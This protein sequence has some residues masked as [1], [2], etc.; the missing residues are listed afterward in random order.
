MRWNIYRKMFLFATMMIVLPVALLGFL[1]YREA[2]AMLISR[3]KQSSLLT[4]ENAANHFIKA[5]I[6]DIETTMNILSNDPMLA[7]LPA[8]QARSQL[9]E[10]WEQH[11]RYS[12][13]IWSI[14]YTSNQ[15]ERFMIPQR[16]MEAGYISPSRNAVP[17]GIIWSK[18]QRDETTNTTVVTA[19]KAIYQDGQLI[20]VFAIDT[21]LYKLSD[22]IHNIHIGAGGY[23]ILLDGSG[24]VIAH[25]ELAMLGTNVRDTDWFKQLTQSELNFIHIADSQL[26]VSS[27]NIPETGW[28]LVGFLPESL[29]VSEAEPIKTTTLEVALLGII[30]ASLVSAVVSRSFVGRIKKLVASVVKIEQGDYQIR[31]LDQSTD[32]I[33]ELSRKF[34]ATADRLS[35]FMEQRDLNEAE[36]QRQKIYFAQLFE[37]SPESIVILDPAGRIVTVNK[38][39]T[40]LFHYTEAEAAGGWIDDLVVPDHLKAEGIDVGE[41]IA[42]HEFVQQETVRKRRD[43]SL[44]EVQ[45][46]AYPIIVDTQI[47]GVYAIYRD[48]SVRKAAEHQLEYLTYHD[49]LT[50]VYNRGYFDRRIQT[51]LAHEAGGYGIVVFDVD[52]LKLVNDSFGHAKGDEL[53]KT[54]VSL[55]QSAAPPEAIIARMG[56]DEF[57][58]LWPQA[59]EEQL[60]NMMKQLLQ[61]ISDFNAAHP[62]F[63]V[64]LSIGFALA[65][66]SAHII[67]ALQEADSRMYK[68]K[69]HRSQSTR[70]AI[71]KTLMRALHARDYITE[72]HGDRIQTMIEQLAERMGISGYKIQDLRLFAQFH[73]LG[74]VGIP[75]SI[76]F[77]SGPLTAKELE[78]MRRH[79]E[80]G[81]RIAISSPELNHIADWILKHHEWWNG[82]G[83]P[84]G[85]SGLEIPLECRILAICD[86]Y[87]AMTSERPYRKAMPAETALV[88]IEKCR[89]SMFDPEIAGIFVA[90]IRG[91]THERL[92]GDWQI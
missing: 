29:F 12:E 56:G 6:H 54:A 55:I 75:D 89:G 46:I 58:L 80:I 69:L 62:E 19:S 73:D 51:L 15:G 1:S 64:S 59:T 65:E 23:L 10:K 14:A 48:I 78:V 79:S 38:Q 52:G 77:K 47:A 84:I 31:D 26:Y 63:S 4:M 9:T 8:T 11:R 83:Y 53:L 92:F 17:T 60:Q 43:G 30:L 41:K 45:V 49:A 5:Y 82:Q 61:N 44:V 22:I 70:S 21:S 40:E 16:N 71:V 81:Y 90:M 3:I 87:D 88:E 39:F 33:G 18:P 85:I 24:N 76:L 35:S 86:A 28:T 27:V 32:E 91:T 34:A 72:G 67:E 50:G 13:N 42:A 66:K 25:D 57:S 7:E 2:E 37:N 36:I 68:E 74:K 20:G